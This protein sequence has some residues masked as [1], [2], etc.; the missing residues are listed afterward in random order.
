MYQHQTPLAQLSSLVKH[1]ESLPLLT[2]HL[3]EEDSIQQVFAKAVEEK[4]AA[5][6]ELSD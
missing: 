3:R 4:E 2:D 5:A 1:L 6:A